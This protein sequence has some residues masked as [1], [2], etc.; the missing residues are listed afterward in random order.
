MNLAPLTFT[1][2]HADLVP[3]SM[4]H[5]DDLI[6]AVRDG[7][8]WNL[9]FTSVPSPGTAAAYI[10]KALKGQHDGHMLPWAVRD[11][12]TNTIVGTTRYHDIVATIDRVEIG[13][14]WYASRCQRTHTNTTCKL[15]LLEYGFDTLGCAVIGLRTDN[16]NLRSQRAI[17]AL[18]RAARFLAP[19][20]RVRHRLRD[21][22]LIFE[23]DGQQPLSV[24]HA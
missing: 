24:E 1:G 16:F 12:A 13:W 11:L 7:E 19:D 8:L 17:E 6:D 14:T 3:L 21:V 20:R 10:E 9:W 15:L 23:L 22:Q 18:V 2:K 5:H 4:A